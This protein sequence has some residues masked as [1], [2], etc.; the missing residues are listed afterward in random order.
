LAD[1]E[2][3]LAALAQASVRGVLLLGPRAGRRA[4]QLVAHAAADPAQPHTRTG[5]GFDLHAKRRISARDKAGREQLCRYILRPP[6]SHS[7]LERLADGRLRLRLKTPWRDGTTHLV[8]TPLELMQKLVPLVWPPRFHRLRY[9]G[10]FAPN[11]KL[12]GA[13][14]P[15]PPAAE[16]CEHGE[17]EPANASYGQRKT[18]AALLARVFELDVLECPKCKSRMQRIAFITT[19]DA[20][21]KILD[22][23]GHAADSPAAA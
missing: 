3:G 19:A 15:E 14:V 16:V 1:S 9:H 7:R 23:V 8:L 21:R 11:A 12:R 5:Y 2:P 4:M 10:V 17:V 20:I 22:A 13:V 6:L 18:W